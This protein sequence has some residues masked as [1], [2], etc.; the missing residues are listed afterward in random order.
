[1][2]CLLPA[3]LLQ[4]LLSHSGT[5]RPLPPGLVSDCP[6]LGLP[7]ASLRWRLSVNAPLLALSPIDPF[8]GL[9]AEES[10][11]GLSRKSPLAGLSAKPSVLE[12]SAD[13]PALGLPRTIPETRL[14]SALALSTALLAYNK[15]N[16]WLSTKPTPCKREG[17]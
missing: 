11:R 7:E 15:A 3:E 13:R 1:M 8:R 17:V 14:P 12:L 9:R 10:A 6:G 4:G 16:T 2:R 5:E